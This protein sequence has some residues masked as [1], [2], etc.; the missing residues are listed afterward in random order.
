MI[1]VA[2]FVENWA[3]RPVVDKTG[4]SGMFN[5]QTTGWRPDDPPPAQPRPDG[6]PLSEEQQRFADPSTPTMA[7]IFEQLGLKLEAQRA[8]VET[9]TLVS[10]QRPTEN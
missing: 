8:T 9:Y 5:I 1:D 3:G 6:Q 10:V 4:L 2:Q 7:D